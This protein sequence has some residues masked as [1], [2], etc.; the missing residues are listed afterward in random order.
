MCATLMLAYNTYE[1]NIE[2]FPFTFS[3]SCFPAAPLSTEHRRADRPLRLC[4]ETA[5]AAMTSAQAHCRSPSGL[6]PVV[7]LCPHVLPWTAHTW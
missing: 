3:S 2:G 4:P 7:S 6:P 1:L 5:F